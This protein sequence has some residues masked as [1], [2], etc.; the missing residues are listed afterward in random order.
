MLSHKHREIHEG[1][2]H[3]GPCHARQQQ[4]GSGNGIADKV[5]DDQGRQGRGGVEL[6]APPP[7]VIVL[8]IV[9]NVATTVILL[10]SPIVCFAGNGG[11]GGI[12]V[13]KGSPLPA[14]PRAAVR[15]PSSPSSPLAHPGGRAGGTA[16]HLGGNG[17]GGPLHPLP[18]PPAARL[19][20]LS[21]GIRDGH[22][23]NTPL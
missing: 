9:P 14:S 21:L 3:T 2:S 19:P 7:L 15:A 23:G 22:P 13:L 4:A 17:T 1:Y 5:A 20:S 8:I 6:R 11:G 16:P 18:P 12:V 10:L